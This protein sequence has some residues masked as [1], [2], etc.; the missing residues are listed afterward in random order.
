[1]QSL[2]VLAG[3]YVM[4]VPWLVMNH[5]NTRTAVTSAATEV[6]TTALAKAERM[7]IMQSWPAL[8]LIP[9]VDTQPATRSIEITA[10][11]GI[12]PRG[13][14]VGD[15]ITVEVD[16]SLSRPIFRAAIAALDPTLDAGAA[17]NSG[18][19]SQVSCLCPLAMRHLMFFIGREKEDLLN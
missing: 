6:Q 8:E 4:A 14:K 16:G 19:E 15:Q 13:F 11:I 1:M 2:L 7:R 5:L 17:L 12:C 10:A 18:T 3:I 9:S